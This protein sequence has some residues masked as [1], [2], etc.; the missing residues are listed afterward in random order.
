MPQRLADLVGR[1]MI[2]PEF[3]SDLQRAPETVL[4]QYELNDEERRAVREALL[5]LTDT[6]TSQRA[7]ALRMA[8]L[9]RVAT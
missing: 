7:A 2:D 4:A 9:R 5:R 3:L 8:L 6:P 1:L